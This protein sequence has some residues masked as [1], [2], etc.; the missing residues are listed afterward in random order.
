[1]LG[2]SVLHNTA[3]HIW[4][5]SYASCPPGPLTQPAPKHVNVF[6]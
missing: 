4:M 5:G 2:M 1:M 3:L 6:C